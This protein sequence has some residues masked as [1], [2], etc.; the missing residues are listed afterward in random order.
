M[1]D[2]EKFIFGNMYFNFEYG[3]AS[4]YCYSRE[5]NYNYEYV[6]DEY[7]N[8]YFDT[9]PTQE[10]RDKVNRTGNFLGFMYGP[11]SDSIDVAGYQADVYFDS[12]KEKRVPERLFKIQI[13][14]RNYRLGD[15]RDVIMPYY[16][17]DHPSYNLETG[18]EKNEVGMSRGTEFLNQVLEIGDIVDLSLYS[19]IISF[20]KFVLGFDTKFEFKWQTYFPFVSR[21]LYNETKGQYGFQHTDFH[22][23]WDFG[24]TLSW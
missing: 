5:S 15:E 10:E 14:F 2:M 8:R 24:I 6:R 18:K 3:I 23:K 19:D 1:S 12:F 11:N 20:S 9:K 21:D 17:N 22:F 7:K 4:K 13:H 16:W